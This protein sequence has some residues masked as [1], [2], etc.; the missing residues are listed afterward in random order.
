MGKVKKKNKVFIGEKD[1]S[2][3]IKWGNE[4]EKM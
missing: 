2:L 4:I 3:V 1:L